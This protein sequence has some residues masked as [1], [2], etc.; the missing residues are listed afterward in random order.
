MEARSWQRS[1]GT[2]PVALVHGIGKKTTGREPFAIGR[3]QMP[4]Q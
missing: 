3:L 4:G 1:L 2:A